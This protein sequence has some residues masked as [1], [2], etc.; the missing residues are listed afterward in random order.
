M[1]DSY[2][3]SLKDRLK[4]LDSKTAEKQFYKWS[5]N[6]LVHTK[7][8]NQ[9]SPEMYVLL[10]KY[11]I[12][13]INTL[14]KVHPELAQKIQRF[15]S[16]NGLNKDKAEKISKNF[17]PDKYCIFEDFTNFIEKAFE[18]VENEYK[19]KILNIKEFSNYSQIIAVFKLI[20]DLIDMVE[21]WKE[22]D[23][24]LQKFQKLCKFRV[25]QIMRA[26]K[27]YEES[28]E[29]KEYEN[30]ISQLKEQIK[31]D[32]IMEEKRKKEEEEKAKKKAF[33]TKTYTISATTSKKNNPYNDIKLTNP[34]IMKTIKDDNYGITNPFADMSNNP[35]N[36]PKP[37][38]NKSALV[39]KY[40]KKR[41]IYSKNDK[42]AQEINNMYDNYDPGEYQQSPPENNNINNN[43]G[44]FYNV[45]DRPYIPV[46][47]NNIEDVMKQLLRGY[48]YPGSKEIN[49]GEI[50]VLYRSTD[51][52]KLRLHIKSIL[53]P[54]IIGQLQKNNAEEAY[55]NSKML[56]YYL[57][58]MN[59]Q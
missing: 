12:H 1:S 37:S 15:Y 30:E 11:S 19:E 38:V 56:M 14:S 9:Y 8:I 18:A 51:F 13:Y 31:Q 24:G 20:C 23:E 3:K 47:K 28:P 55:Q 46:N 27:A 32:K 26:K 6:Y 41:V 59:P 52:Y 21:I 43:F 2:L 44:N 48:E 29:G 36:L 5:Y 50:P 10:L 33:L 53:I 45:Y 57:S 58:I 17:N 49:I 22:K 35:Y 16:E 54:K 40:T 25:I 7:A 42:E 39:K 34:P 4:K